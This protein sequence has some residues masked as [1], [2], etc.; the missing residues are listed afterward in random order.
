MPLVQLIRGSSQMGKLSHWVGAFL[1][2]A[3]ELTA[4]IWGPVRLKD[5]RAALEILNL[6][7]QRGL[8][9]LLAMLHVR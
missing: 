8:G 1:A 7:I 2:R 5:V 6:I 4:R 9:V 3:E